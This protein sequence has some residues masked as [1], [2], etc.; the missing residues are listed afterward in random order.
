MA[1]TL[2]SFGHFGCNR[3]NKDE[4]PLTSKMLIENSIINFNDFPLKKLKFYFVN[5]PV[6]PVRISLALLELEGRSFLIFSGFYW[7][8]L[9]FP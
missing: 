4:R 7:G 2:W 9:D 1:K 8:I 6:D 3:A 5:S